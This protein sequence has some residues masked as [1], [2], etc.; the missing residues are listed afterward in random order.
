VFDQPEASR[1][2]PDTP[3]PPRF[4]PEFDNLILSHADRTRIIA[5]E[6]RKAITSRNGM[7]PATFLFDG[8]VRGTWRTERSH[9]KATLVIEPFEALAKDERSVLAGAAHTVRQG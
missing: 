8:F 1:P 6:Y 7:V 3:S 5:D 9:R 2:D 4:L